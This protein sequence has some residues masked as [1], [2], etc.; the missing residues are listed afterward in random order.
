[1]SN[2]SEKLNLS[3][4]DMKLRICFWALLSPGAPRLGAAPSTQTCL[5]KSPGW[6]VVTSWQIDNKTKLQNL[7]ITS[8]LHLYHLPLFSLYF[9]KF[10]WW[11]VCFW[12]SLS[13]PPRLFAKLLTQNKKGDLVNFFILQSW[14]TSNNDGGG[15]RVWLPGLSQAGGGVCHCA[16]RYFC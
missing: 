2:C 13:F 9:S 15:R 3:H 16:W 14:S 12:L 5:P 7:N 10:H 1:M 4:V 11:L 8:P 6:K